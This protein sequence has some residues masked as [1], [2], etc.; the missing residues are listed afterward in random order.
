VG[1]TTPPGKKYTITKSPEPIEDDHGGGED[2]HRVVEPVR[3]T[4]EVPLRE[5]TL[6]VSIPFC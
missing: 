6:L 5:I 2:P 1:L 3:K 4:K